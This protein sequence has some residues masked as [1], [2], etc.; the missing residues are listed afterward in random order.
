MGW[1]VQMENVGYELIIVEAGCRGHG[2]HYVCVV[3]QKV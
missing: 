3:L 1:G 2:A